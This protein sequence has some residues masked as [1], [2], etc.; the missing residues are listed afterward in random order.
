MFGVNKEGQDVL[1][2]Q[3]KHGKG[4]RRPSSE[5]LPNRDPELEMAIM[6]E[7]L[8]I[9]KSTK[10]M[11]ELRQRANEVLSRNLARHPQEGE[12]QRFIESEVARLAEGRV[13][14]HREEIA[15]MASRAAVLRMR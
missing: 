3:F 4:S 12:V 1:S 7:K 5:V 2:P 13:K 8:S 11:S 6:S 10:I 14:R 9:T 15:E